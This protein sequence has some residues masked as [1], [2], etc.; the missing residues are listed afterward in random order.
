MR[1]FSSFCGHKDSDGLFNGA[2]INM[3]VCDRAYGTM[4]DDFAMFIMG[5]EL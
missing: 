2:L 3:W 1:W 5:G 4:N